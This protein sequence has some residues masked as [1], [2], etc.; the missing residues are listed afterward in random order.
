MTYKLL[1][2]GVRRIADGACIPDAAGNSDWRK[3]QDWL[4]AGN[5]PEP[6]DPEPQVFPVVTMRQA[7]LALHGAGLLT[8]VNGAVAAIGGEAAIEWEYATT[9]D[10]NS[11]LVTSLA[12]ALNLSEQEIDALFEVAKT[13]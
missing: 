7:R 5:T 8:Q 1:K 13:L 10:R 9:V 4:S 3:Y 12:T 6:A 2:S 11:P